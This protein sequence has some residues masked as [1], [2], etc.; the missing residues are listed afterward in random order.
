MD[1]SLHIP[2]DLPDVRV[3]NLSKTE[4]GAWLIQIESTL[5][6]TTC[7]KC[8]REITELHCH[9]GAIRLRHLPIFEIPVYVEIR[10]KRFRCLYCKDHPTTTQRLEWHEARSPNTT[11][12]EHWLL[13]MLINSTVCD[14]G[15]KLGISEDVV[16]G[17]IDRWI[18]TQVEWNDFLELTVLGIDEIS[19]KRGHRDFVVIITTPTAYGVDILGVLADRKQQTVASFLKS[20][21]ITL[22]QTIERVCTD[23]YPGFVGAVREQLPQ[24]KIVI[25]RFHVAKGY[26]HCADKVRQRELK[27]LRQELP[28]T[29][30]QSLKGAMWV[31]R[32]PSNSLKA[33][34]QELLERL[35]GYSPELQ[36]AYNLREELT[37]IF[38]GKDSKDGAKYAIEAWCKRV[39]II[40]VKEFESFLT[41]LE[42]WLDEITNYFLEGWT[43]GFVEGFNN[44]VKV[45]KRRCYGI[46]NIESLFQRIYLD[47]HGYEKFA[48]P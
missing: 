45:L 30:Y 27:R 29:E 39:Q 9:D 26:R 32:K 5:N 16:T 4:Q 31:F 42:N 34:E 44:R 19:L 35:F 37:E 48:M 14:V 17:T 10:P 40:G 24:A 28:K 3:L 46:F 7:H 13:R 47:L 6:S 23:M 21:P 1:S 8:G 2:L 20:I 38:E 25:D 41:T 36:Q 18:S 12:Y 15:S 33:S 43:S 22:R 11:P